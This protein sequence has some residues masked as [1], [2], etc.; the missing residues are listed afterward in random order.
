MV[1]RLLRYKRRIF[2]NPLDEHDEYSDQVDRLQLHLDKQSHRLPR[3]DHIYRRGPPKRKPFARCHR[4]NQVDIR[5]LRIPHSSMN[6]ILCSLRYLGKG[7]R[8]VDN[9]LLILVARDQFYLRRNRLRKDRRSFL[10][11]GRNHQT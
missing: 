5:T 8:G 3:I 9:E 10:A 4:P 1:L 7:R 2:C 6:K 11:S